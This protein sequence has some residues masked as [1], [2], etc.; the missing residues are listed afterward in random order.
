MKY[1]ISNHQNSNFL[2]KNFYHISGKKKTINYTLQDYQ[3]D[4]VKARQIQTGSQTN[5]FVNLKT[6]NLV[7]ASSLS[8]ENND[9][10]YKAYEKVIEKLGKIEKGTKE[11]LEAEKYVQAAYEYPNLCNGFDL[12][13]AEKYLNN[14]LEINARKAGTMPEGAMGQY[15][16]ASLQTDEI[17]VKDAFANDV[18]VSNIRTNVISND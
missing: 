4:I 9:V 2:Q 11:A 17:K 3:K 6:D 10:N 7:K 12:H 14:Y 13:A 18:V 5:R 8:N 16:E 1:F 15:K